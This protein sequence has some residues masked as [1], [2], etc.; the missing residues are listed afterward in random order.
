MTAQFLN[1]II[2]ECTALKGGASQV[3]KLSDKLLMDFQYWICNLVKQDH[4]SFLLPLT[5]HKFYPDFICELKDGRMLVGELWVEVS[6][7]KC[8]FIMAVEQDNQGR[9]VRQQILSLIS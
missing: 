1:T 8:L 2:N 5:H 9:D 3:F 7:G 6:N 4:A